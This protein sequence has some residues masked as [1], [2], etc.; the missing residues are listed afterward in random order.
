MYLLHDPINILKKRWRTLLIS[1]CF[2]AFVAGVVSLAF[3]LEYRADAQILI[4]SKSRYG[5]DPYTAVKSAERV[6]E[7]VVQVLSSDV[8]YQSVLEE[9]GP[10]T[11][12]AYF[13]EAENERERRKRWEHSVNASVVYGTGVL[14]VSAFATTK[15]GA[16]ALSKAVADALVNRVFDYIGGDVTLKIIN[17]PVATNVPVRPN[18]PLNVGVGFLV[19]LFLS[20]IVV[21]RRYR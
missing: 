8:F 20:G 18:V 16:V 6:G 12:T 13:L 7:N 21:V 9:A 14:N 2:V 15:E 19:G 17:A 3:P 4:V 5:I 10:G 11:P 1:G